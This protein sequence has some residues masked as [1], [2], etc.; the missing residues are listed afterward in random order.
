M[1]T[2]MFIVEKLNFAQEFL[3]T[4]KYSLFKYAVSFGLEFPAFRKMSL[5]SFV[6]LKFFKW[7]HNVWTACP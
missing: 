3:Q 7:R 4:F 6:A 5:F 1:V 2:A